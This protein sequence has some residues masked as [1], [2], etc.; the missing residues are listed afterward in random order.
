LAAFEEQLPG[1][2][3]IRVSAMYTRN[4][5]TR[6][7]LNLARPYDAYN[8]PITSPDPGP[9]GIVGTGDDPGKSLTY[10]DYPAAL[11]GLQFQQLTW[12]NPPGNDQT[13]RTIEVA[14]NKRL[15]TGWQ[16]MGSYS[17]TK[18]NAPTVVE[19]AY[20]PNNDI[21]VAD[22]TWEWSGKASAAYMMPRGVTV[23][24]NYDHRSGMPFARQVLLRGGKQVT[25]LVVNAEPVGSLRLPNL[26]LVD[27]RA[28]KSF[29]M[30]GT[31]R[32]IARVNLYNVL[33]ASSVTA[34]SVR[35]GPTYLTPTAIVPPRIVEFAASYSF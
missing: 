21:N 9:D 19:S 20:T 22:H 6:R 15:S 35:S 17:A 29:K 26:N 14:A 34:W 30:S 24:V 16:L 23:S 4:F 18:L 13:F 10:Y 28:E 1:T 33:N 3:A 27:F 5:N 7:I 31:Q 25:S 12:F 32:V 11:A 8:I 2:A